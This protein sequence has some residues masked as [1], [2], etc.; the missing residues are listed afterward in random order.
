MWSCHSVVAWIH[1]LNQ[2]LIFDYVSS[3]QCLPREVSWSYLPRNS[4]KF[5]TDVSSFGN[6]GRSGFGGVIC[7]F[8]A[9]WVVGYSSY[10]GFIMNMATELHAI[11]YSV[12][13]DFNSSL[14][15]FVCELD[16]SSG[17][18][19]LYEGCIPTHPQ[20]ALVHKIKFLSSNMKYECIFLACSKRRKCR[21]L[22]I[23]QKGC[24]YNKCFGDFNF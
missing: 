15:H 19:L 17:L 2:N 8:L 12:K 7:D 16:S 11:W 13:L 24:N 22:Q 6:P 3:N 4:F 10:Y 5:N 9:N 18:G 21:G 20:A 14:S 1:S 23:S